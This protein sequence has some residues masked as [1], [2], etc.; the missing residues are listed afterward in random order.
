EKTEEITE[1]AEEIISEKTEEITEVA[2]EI[3]SEKEEA[4]AII[5]EKETEKLVE[6][7]EKHS[8]ILEIICPKCGSHNSRKNGFYKD[9][10]RYACKDCGKQFVPES[11]E[12]ITE[13][14]TA[15]T[16]TKES[17]I[18]GGFSG[19]SANRSSK[20]KKKGKR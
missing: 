16:P 3:I 20:N 17:K 10:Q 14:K 13:I 7:A 11:Q 19:K 1:V 9:K 8:P 15:K 2:E 6:T 4:I 12:I 5:P 18:K